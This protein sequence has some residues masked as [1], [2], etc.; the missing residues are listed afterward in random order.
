MITLYIYWLQDVTGLQ[1]HSY[2]HFGDH[3]TVSYE[4]VHS[5]RTE[6][7]GYCFVSNR[8][9]A[10]RSLV[11][12]TRT[13]LQRYCIFCNRTAVTSAWYVLEEPSLSASFI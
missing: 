1:Q 12:K 13:K 4:L 9:T 6:L 11:Y 5:W 2:K 7:R 10:D 3:T 8:T